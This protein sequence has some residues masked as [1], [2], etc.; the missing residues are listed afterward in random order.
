[1]TAVRL[2]VCGWPVAHSRSPRMHNAALAALGLDD[3]RYQLLPVPPERLAETVRAL[4]EAGFRG[5]NVTIPHKEAAFALAD[6]VTETARAVGAANTLTFTDTGVQ[7]DNT[8]VTGFLS[9]LPESVYDR[10]ALVLG[11]GGSARAV[12][13]ALRQAGARSI[14]VWNRTP[15]RAEA[16]AREFGAIAGAARA[17]VIVNCTAVGLKSPESTFKMLPLQADE[18]G[19]GQLV[20]DLVYRPGG[21]ALLATAKANGAAVAGGLE[22]LVAQ[23]AASLERWTGRTAPVEAMREAVRDVTA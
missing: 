8:D 13:Y 20:V 2:G 4:P 10:D 19:A 18:V 17:E 7:A 22:I 16:L 15:A 23:G 5:I 12:L 9:A 6:A 1:V 21:T 14:H 11:A 3:W